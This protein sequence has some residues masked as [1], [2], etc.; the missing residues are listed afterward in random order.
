MPGA[1]SAEYGFAE[2]DVGQR[3]HPA[4][5]SEGIV[6]AVDGAATGVGGD[7]GKQRGVGNAEADFLAFHVAAGL[8]QAGVL[9]HS[10]EQRIAFALPPSTR[11]SRRPRT[12]SPWPPRPPSHDAAIR[13]FGRACRSARPESRRSK[14]S[15]DK[16]LSGVGFSKGCALLALK[17]PPPF[18]PSILIVS[19]DATGPCAI[20]WSVTVSIT[21]LPS[22]AHH[23]FAVGDSSALAAVRPASPCRTV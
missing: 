21:G 14:S 10:L 12:E 2:H 9:V 19:C 22:R 15:A 8:H 23:R 13:S 17:K 5:R 4:Q 3:H 20:T 11:W 16:L 7:G 6:P 18:V 1:H